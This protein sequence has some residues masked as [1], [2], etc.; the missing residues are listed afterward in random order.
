MSPVIARRPFKAD[1]P[2][3]VD[4][5]TVLAFAIAFQRFKTIARQ[6]R[7]IFERDSRFQTVQFQTR[8][9]FYARETFDPFAGR[10]VYS[11]FVPVADDHT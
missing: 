11:P 9:A 4:A 2:T 7:K 3:V 1:P 8:G 10:K 5:N 6:G